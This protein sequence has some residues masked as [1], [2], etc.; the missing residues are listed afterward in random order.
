MKNAG[1]ILLSITT[2]FT[3]A[4]FIFGCGDGEPSIP[5]STPETSVVEPTPESTPEPTPTPCGHN[6]VEANCK[7]SKSCL[8]CGET[9]GVALGHDWKEANFQERQTCLLCGAVEGSPLISG[10]SIHGLEFRVPFNNVQILPLYVEYKTVTSDGSTTTRGSIALGN[11]I[12]SNQFNG[13]EAMDGYEFVTVRFGMHFRDTAAQRDGVI[14]AFGCFDYYNFDP[15]KEITLYEDMK[16]SNIDGFKILRTVNYF[17]EEFEIYIHHNT[18]NPGWH[19]RHDGNNF[20][21]VEENT[22]LLPVG[23]DGITIYFFNGKYFYAFLNDEEG[24][25]IGDMLDND[26]LFFRL[27][28]RETDYANYF[29][30]TKTLVCIH[31]ERETEYERT[32]FGWYAIRCGGCRGYSSQNW[33]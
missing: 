14:W 15:M 13:I 30:I 19:R 9:E 1:K 6:W 17:G 10:V 29:P 11:Y 8:D 18:I 4:T 5:I 33:Y 21:I 27:N 20:V 7:D 26:A 28:L 3:L 25:T 31:C 22:Y 12:I 32:D 2:L 16:D 23:Y 24:L